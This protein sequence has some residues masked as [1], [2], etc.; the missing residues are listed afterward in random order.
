MRE[1][2]ANT[3]VIDTGEGSV[4]P[5]DLEKTDPAGFKGFLPRVTVCDGRVVFFG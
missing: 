1:K 2:G 5:I 4:L 3:R